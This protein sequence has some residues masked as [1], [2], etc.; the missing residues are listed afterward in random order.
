MSE[1][2]ATEIAAAGRALLRLVPEEGPLDTPCWVWLGGRTGVGYGSIRVGANVANVHA[3]IYRVLAGPVPAE[4]EL[5]HRCENPLCANPE[6]LTPLTSSEH[7]LIHQRDRCDQGHPFT[8]ET[9]LRW[10]DGRRRCRTC[11]T[12]RER[13][14]RTA[15]PLSVRLGT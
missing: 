5:H 9:T 15:D 10:A 8:E 11:K 6:H 12:G 4:L 7:A 3:L 1:I 14:R 13:D 2:A